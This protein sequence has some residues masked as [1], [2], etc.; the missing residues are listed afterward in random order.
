MVV[1]LEE[2]CIMDVV[3]MLP[4]VVVLLEEVD[5][6]ASIVLVDSQVAVWESSAERD[7]VSKVSYVRYAILWIEGVYVESVDERE[8]LSPCWG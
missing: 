5:S 3:C 1:L 8:M 6:E 4:D 2:D 7:V